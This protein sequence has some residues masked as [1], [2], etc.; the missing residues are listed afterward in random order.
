MQLDSEKYKSSFSLGYNHFFELSTTDSFQNQQY[1]YPEEIC[2]RCYGKPYLN[3][4]IMFISLFLIT[5]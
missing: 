3:I 4:S 1:M 2:I 5:K